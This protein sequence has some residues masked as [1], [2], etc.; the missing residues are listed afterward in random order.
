M[1]AMA[2][3]RYGGPEVLEAMDLAEPKVGPDSVLLRTR[4]VGV[5]PVDYKIRE[6]A[7]D[8]LIPAHFPLVPGFDVA[9]VVERVG[10]AVVGIAP[11]DEVVAY[12]RQDHVEVG[13]YAELTSVPQ[14]AV[15]QDVE[16]RRPRLVAADEQRRAVV[17]DIERERRPQREQ[18][19]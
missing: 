1:L 17:G 7:L 3:T 15:A 9:G 11:G 13:T 12:N 18:R 19:R 8:G 14:R 16:L 4:A 10:P 2:L 6:G 5:N